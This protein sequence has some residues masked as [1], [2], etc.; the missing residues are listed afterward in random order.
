MWK[1]VPQTSVERPISYLRSWY[2]QCSC[3]LVSVDI[4]KLTKFK[5]VRNEEKPLASIKYKDPKGQKPRN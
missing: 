5:E 4:E 1:N 2:E 3:S